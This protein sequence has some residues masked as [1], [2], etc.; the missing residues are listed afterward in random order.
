MA[1]MFISAGLSLSM[2]VSLRLFFLI[3]SILCMFSADD[4][5][6]SIKGRPSLVVP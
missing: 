3:S 6:A 4:T 2:P 1:G 5:T